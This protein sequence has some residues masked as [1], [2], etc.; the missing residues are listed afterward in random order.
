MDNNRNLEYP[1]IK[2]VSVV[3][4]VKDWIIDQ[5]I[6]GNLRPGSKLPT[7]AELCSNLG[8][9][10]NSV[11]EAIKQ[12]EAYGVVY[13]KRA[14]GTFVTDR[15]DP[16]MLS[17]V[18]YSIILQNNRWEDF[19]DLRRAIDIGTLYVLIGR[20]PAY[21]E[22]APLRQALSALESAVSA[23]VLNVQQITE[24]DCAF[25]N[26]IIG[27]TNNP[28]LVTLSEY[29]NRITVPSRENTTESVIANG[30]IDSYVHLH[31]QLYTIIERGDK[32]GIEQAVLDHYI[33]W[34]KNRA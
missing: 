6:K 22:L 13:I 30:E 1:A 17:P 28:Q 24:A 32:A 23:E 12:L 5:L 29:I 27:L 20:H 33:F 3:D 11:R 25:H 7:E 26:V 15:F 2:T 10:R 16:K 18:L 14:E 34:E 8:A 21:E 31:R 9:S 4:S 19:V